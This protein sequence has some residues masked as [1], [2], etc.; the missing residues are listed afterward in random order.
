M[1]ILLVDD[2]PLFREGM[3][4]VLGQLAAQAMLLE[5]PSGRAALESAGRHPDLDL[6][7][8]D[9]SLPDIGGLDVLATLRE[10][11]PDIP[12]VVLSASEDT[13]DIILAIE[14]GARGYIPK[15]SSSQLLLAALRL[16]FDGGVYVPPA[17]LAPSS[18]ISPPRPGPSIPE[19]WPVGETVIDPALLGLTQRQLEVLKL[20]V[21]GKCNKDIARELGIEESTVKVHVS[22]VLKA[23]KVTNRV[24]AVLAVSQ[25]G[26]K[27]DG[28][29]LGPRDTSA[30]SP[31]TAPDSTPDRE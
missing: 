21:D 2:H 18:G 26:I 10:Q 30:A 15:S 13:G 23:L 5:A 24:Q 14:S 8:L 3:R 6:V 27:F 29:H 31:A 16:V 12:V 4:H 28:L 11:H 9:L 7:L 25:L 19:L 22:P 20:I 1:K 17:V